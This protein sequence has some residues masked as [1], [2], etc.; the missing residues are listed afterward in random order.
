MS[1]STRVDRS[2]TRSTPVVKVPILLIDDD[3]SVRRS[4]GRLLRAHGYDV[5]DAGNLGQA[6]EILAT[7]LPALMLMD[8]V[9]PG[10]DSLNAARKFKAEPRT[11][12]VPIIALTALPPS[13]PQ[14][15]ALFAEV[16]AK[17]SNARVLLDTIARVLGTAQAGS[18][19]S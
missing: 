11:A 2:S 4:L 10:E 7:R 19:A 14:D 3:P 17:P 1:H 5:L 9:M 13:A 18:S 6:L 12:A 16:V 15:Q 8:M